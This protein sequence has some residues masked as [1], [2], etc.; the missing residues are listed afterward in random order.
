MD[1]QAQEV[2]SFSDEEN[3]HISEI[4]LAALKQVLTIEQ[5]NAIAKLI[6]C[7]SAVYGMNNPTR[8]Q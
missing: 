8:K 7:I 4:D 2:E 1:T 3:R 5:F 6:G